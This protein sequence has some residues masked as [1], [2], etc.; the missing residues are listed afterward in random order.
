VSEI[1]G[2]AQR[3]SYVL[4]GEPVTDATALAQMDIPDHE[5][6]VEVGKLQEG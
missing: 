3:D 5:S 1:L 6:C 4:S 2:E